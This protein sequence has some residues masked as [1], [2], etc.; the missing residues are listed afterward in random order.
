MTCCLFAKEMVGT[1][2]VLVLQGYKR[3]SLPGTCRCKMWL[4]LNLPMPS[5]EVPVLLHWRAVRW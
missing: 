2:G 4:K 5:H 3:L 1:D